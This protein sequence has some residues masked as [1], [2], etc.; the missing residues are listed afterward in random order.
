M[1]D[2]GVGDISCL[3]CP[4]GIGF[5]VFQP[6]HSVVEQQDTALLSFPAPNGSFGWYFRGRKAFFEC[7]LVSFP[8]QAEDMGAPGWWC[9][10]A[11][12]G[13]EH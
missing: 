9:L 8:M 13:G 10:R 2:N 4:Q 1:L 3:G 5:S 11:E 6:R 12:C 7:R